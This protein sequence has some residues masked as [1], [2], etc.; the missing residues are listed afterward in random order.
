MLTHNNTLFKMF[1]KMYQV[2]NM[3]IHFYADICWGSIF[4]Q[5]LFEPYGMGPGAPNIAQVALEI[6]L[7]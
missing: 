4:I 2:L 7:G 3:N 1:D 5:M 6:M